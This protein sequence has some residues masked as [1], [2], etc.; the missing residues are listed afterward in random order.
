MQSAYRS[1]KTILFAC[2]ALLTGLAWY[3][4][5]A[6]SADM[7]GMS[8]AMPMPDKVM[9]KPMTF[10][11]LFLMWAIMMVAMMLPAAL[12][13]IMV[14]Y[15]I[16]RKRQSVGRTWVPTWVFISGYILVW[17]LFSASASLAQWWLQGTSWL[18]AD[19]MFSSTTL[20]GTLLLI[21]GAYQWSSLKQRC[22]Q[23][24]RSP[25]S[26]LMSR[27]QEG[28]AGAVRMGLE[29][30]LYCLGCCWLLMALL[31][32]AGVM[33][34]LWVALLTV[35]VILEKLLPRGDLVARISGGF[36]VAAG[37]VFL[38]RTAQTGLM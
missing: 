20:N 27:W 19:M 16:T 1:E 28:S 8:E 26:F 35:L 2:L 30:G 7:S 6:M 4:L 9:G 37:I 14:F 31:F 38:V 22:L 12:P 25:L 15:T 23:F 29:H 11:P 24:C 17:S 33:N 5:V 36:M 34:L 18:S 13:M 32:V 21:A 10:F 3:Y